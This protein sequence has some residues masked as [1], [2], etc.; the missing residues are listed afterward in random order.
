MEKYFKRGEFARLNGIS[1]FT[2]RL[3]DRMGILKP[4]YTDP[5][6]GYHYYSLLQ[7]QQLMS[8]NLCTKAGFSLKEVQQLQRQDLTDN[9]LNSFLIR[10]ESSIQ[11]KLKALTASHNMVKSLRYYSDA[12]Q[13]HGLNHPFL[14]EHITLQGFLSPAKSFS[15]FDYALD[16][17]YFLRQCESIMG[18]PAE[19]PYS[20]IL[21]GS[22]Q[23]QSIQIL[24]RTSEH[25]E[26]DNFYCSQRDLRFLITAFEGSFAHVSEALDTLHD[27]ARSHN[28]QF[29]DYAMLTP[30]Q[31]YLFPSENDAAIFVLGVEVE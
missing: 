22:D 19:Y 28:I 9:E 29:Q 17:N 8:I 5:E 30:V 12:W 15:T 27:Y 6:N 1:S 24:L 7:S 13:S 14:E 2:L 21:K 16:Y 26:S 11:E 10:L 20:F 25:W 3:Y 31:R 4:A 23:N 18:H